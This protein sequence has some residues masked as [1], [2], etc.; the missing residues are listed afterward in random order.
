MLDAEGAI[1]ACS[2]R[3]VQMQVGMYTPLVS[4]LFKAPVMSQT[5]NKT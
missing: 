5:V 1:S 3:V 4:A 2:H